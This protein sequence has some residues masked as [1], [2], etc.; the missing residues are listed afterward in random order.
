MSAQRENFTVLNWTYP[1][2]QYGR[3]ISDYRHIRTRELKNTGYDHVVDILKQCQTFETMHSVVF[4]FSR[5]DLQVTIGIDN[6][7]AAD[8]I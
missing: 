1:D 3:Y 7:F 6:G 4:D 5:E 8:Q 2:C